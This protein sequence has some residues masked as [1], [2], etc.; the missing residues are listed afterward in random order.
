MEYLVHTLFSIYIND[1]PILEENNTFSLLFADDLATSIQYKFKS[2]AQREMQLHL[3]NLEKWSNKMRLQFAPHKCNIIVF[4]EKSSTDQFNLNLYSKPLPQVKSCK[5][6]GI[7]FDEKLN[8]KEHF[9]KLTEKSEERLKILKVLSHSSW[10]LNIKILLCIYKLLIG[11][12]IEYSSIVYD[13]TSNS[14]TKTLQII[15]NDAFRLILKLKREDGNQTIQAIS[16]LEYIADK[17]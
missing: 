8:F 13:I 1:I 6:L 2:D 15:Q 17:A 7:I 14:I 12:F 5:F 10:T 4:S 9:D 3:N 11:L 16:Q